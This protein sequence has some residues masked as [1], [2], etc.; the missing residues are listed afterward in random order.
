MASEANDLSDLQLSTGA[1]RLSTQFDNLRR[2]LTVNKKKQKQ[3]LYFTLK[4]FFL[5]NQLEET[6]RRYELL[7]RLTNDCLVLH[8]SLQT[9]QNQLSPISDTCGDKDLLEDKLKKLIVKFFF[10]FFSFQ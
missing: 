5:Q 6:E 2:D 7:Q 1:K 3:S 4:T 8:Q 10:T 9:I